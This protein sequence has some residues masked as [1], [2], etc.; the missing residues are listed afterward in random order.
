[1]IAGDI[2]ITQAAQ[3]TRARQVAACSGLTADSRNL[4]AGADAMPSK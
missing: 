4:A 2:V 1:V 3:C